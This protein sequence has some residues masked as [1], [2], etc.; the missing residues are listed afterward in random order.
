ML[1]VLLIVLIALAL[2]GALGNAALRLPGGI[3]GFILL[4]ILLIL[5]FD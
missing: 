5:L 1:E 3:L 4:I 2:I